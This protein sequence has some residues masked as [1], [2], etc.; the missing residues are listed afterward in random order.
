MKPSTKL[1]L[2]ELDEELKEPSKTKQKIEKRYTGFTGSPQ[3]KMQARGILGIF[4]IR[5]IYKGKK[6]KWWPTDAVMQNAKKQA[7]EIVPNELEN[8][9]KF[10]TKDFFD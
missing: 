2:K 9:N 4:D 5:G 3:D 1:F 8:E 6:P 7:R 10:N